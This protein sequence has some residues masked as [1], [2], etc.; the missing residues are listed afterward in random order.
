MFVKLTRFGFLFVS[1]GSNFLVSTTVDYPSIIRHIAAKESVENQREN[2]GWTD[3]DGMDEWT[4]YCQNG[5]K[6]KTTKEKKY[7]KRL[8]KEDVRK[9]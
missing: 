2:E 1:F 3:R 7:N 9:K 5:Q 4:E 8:G 6:Q